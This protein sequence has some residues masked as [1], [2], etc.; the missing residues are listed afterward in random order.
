MNSHGASRPAVRMA[1]AHLVAEGEHGLIAVVAVRDEER[2]LAHHP[3][4]PGAAIRI[5]GCSTWSSTGGSR[6]TLFSMSSIAYA[7]S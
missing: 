6:A 3:R 5:C 4:Y 1:A 2:V 7:R